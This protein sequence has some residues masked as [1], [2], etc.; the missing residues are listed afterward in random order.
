[1][2]W[3]LGFDTLA[4]NAIRSWQLCRSCSSISA[5]GRLCDISFTLIGLEVS[6]AKACNGL[7]FVEVAPV[8]SDQQPGGE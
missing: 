8:R 6:A 4:Q 5:D 2:S 3:L 1:L 7:P